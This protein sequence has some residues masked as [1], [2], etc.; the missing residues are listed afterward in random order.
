VRYWLGGEVRQASALVFDAGEG[1]PETATRLP[2]L[3]QTIVSAYGAI[4]AGPAVALAVLR[5][6]PSDAVVT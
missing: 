4:P 2:S 3:V 6:V 1:F 5:P